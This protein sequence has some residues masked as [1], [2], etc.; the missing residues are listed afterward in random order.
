MRFLLLLIPLLFA[1]LPASAQLV[2][3][4]TTPD[5]R[6]GCTQGKTGI[7]RPPEYLAP[8]AGRQEPD[9]HPEEQRARHPVGAPVQQWGPAG[10]DDEHAQRRNRGQHP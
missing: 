2:V 6:V 3:P 4:L 8:C 9:E 7:G 1:A 10:T 5:G